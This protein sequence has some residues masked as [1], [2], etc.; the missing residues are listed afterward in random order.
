M[1]AKAISDLTCADTLWT[2]AD[3][4]RGQVNAAEYMIE[5]AA[6]VIREQLVRIEH[7]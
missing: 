6:H 4:I 3:A 7:V 2:A 1:T 5:R